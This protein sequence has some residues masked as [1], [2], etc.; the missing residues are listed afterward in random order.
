MWY[1][2][3]F[4]LPADSKTK[5]SLLN[6]KGSVK[7]LIFISMVNISALHENGAMAVGFDLTPYIKYGQENVMAVRIDNN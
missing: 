1:R 6:L 4:R 7:E 3:H 5:K 2:K